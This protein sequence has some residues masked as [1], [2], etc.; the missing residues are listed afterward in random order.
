MQ[1]PYDDFPHLR[2]L[3]LAALGKYLFWPWPGLLQQRR[4]TLGSMKPGISK[5]P[6]PSMT[7]G[8]TPT[9]GVIPRQEA[10][11]R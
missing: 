5:R 10:A 7:M 2:I 11:A 6:P 9:G 3:L 1:R 4:G 8:S